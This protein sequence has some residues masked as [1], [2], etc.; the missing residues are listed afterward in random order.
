MRPSPSD[1]HDLS[2]WNRGVMEP[3]GVEM[4]A[5]VVAVVFVLKSDGICSL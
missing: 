3:K 4:W 1:C 5:F 2:T